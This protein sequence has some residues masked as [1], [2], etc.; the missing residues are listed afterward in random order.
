MDAKITVNNEITGKFF[1]IHHNLVDDKR[2]GKMFSR[3]KNQSIRSKE[4]FEKFCKYLDCNIYNSLKYNDGF[5][6]AALTC[7]AYVETTTRTVQVWFGDRPAWSLMSNLDKNKTSI[8]SQDGACLLYS[9]GENGELVTILYPGKTT[10]WH[11]EEEN[12]IMR[13][14]FFDCLDLMNFLRKDLKDLVMYQHISSVDI[15]ETYI[16]KWRYRWLK[17]TRRVKIPGEKH[18]NPSGIVRLAILRYSLQTVF[19]ASL[20]PIIIIMLLIFCAFLGMD[21]LSSY[22]R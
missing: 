7:G 19:I 10:V 22:L 11:L 5:W 14:G 16:E 8:I 15:N 18:T 3:R 21:K 4:E 2:L 20:K 6:E 13:V 12:I 1:E 9:L 17:A